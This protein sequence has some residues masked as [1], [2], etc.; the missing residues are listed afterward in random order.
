MVE[1]ASAYSPLK[2]DSASGRA[3]ILSRDHRLLAFTGSDHVVKV[4]DMATGRG[5]STFTHEEPAIPVGFASDGRFLAIKQKSILKLNEIET[6]CEVTR[7][8]R[9]VESAYRSRDDNYLVI[10]YAAEGEVVRLIASN[11]LQEIIHYSSGPMCH[12]PAFSRDGRL[13][14]MANRYEHIVQ[15][16]DLVNGTEQWRIAPDVQFPPRIGPCCPEFSPDG[17][18]LAVDVLGTVMLYDVSTGTVKSRLQAEW[19]KQAASALTPNFS[20]DGRALAIEAFASSGQG[21]TAGL[22]EVEGERELVSVHSRASG[23]DIYKTRGPLAKFKFAFSPDSHFFAVRSD[24]DDPVLLFE[25]TTGKELA[26]MELGWGFAGVLFS[27]DGRT[28]AA[29]SNNG[30]VRLLDVETQRVL[31]TAQHAK[32][33]THMEFSPDSRFLV[34][35]SQDGT[36]LMM[37]TVTGKEIARFEHGAPITQASFSHDGQSLLTVSDDKVKLWSADPN[38]PFDQLCARAGRNLSREEWRTFIGESEPW[39][40]TCPKRHVPD[41]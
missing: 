31:G 34:T 32:A 5:V 35:S 37:E 25:V 10:R 12:Q 40:A 28:L 36:A 22:F 9:N 2:L 11:S 8:Q 18:S 16:F 13:V 19:A 14:A 33:V 41:S 1:L 24:G 30:S 7:L 15:L 29:A 3:V 6:G 20:P 21:V 27:P 4:V 17:Q 23:V 26:R 38:W 39:R